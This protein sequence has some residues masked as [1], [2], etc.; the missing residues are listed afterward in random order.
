MIEARKKAILYHDKYESLQ[1]SPDQLIEDLALQ[2]DYGIYTY[3]IQSDSSRMIFKCE[4]HVEAT[5]ETWI[6][7]LQDLVLIKQMHPKIDDVYVADQIGVDSNILCHTVK[8]N[9]F[10]RSRDFAYSNNTIRLKNGDAVISRYSVTHSSVPISSP[11]RGEL[12]SFIFLNSV[13]SNKTHITNIH[14]VDI[15]VLEENADINTK[16]G[17][18]GKTNRSDDDSNSLSKLH[19]VYNPAGY[20]KLLKT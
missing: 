15:K 5:V 20:F 9:F 14:D 12:N 18:Q 19:K 13:G 17:S 11:V 1:L 16:N 3:M 6:E 4:L 8:G 7:K 10:N 2:N